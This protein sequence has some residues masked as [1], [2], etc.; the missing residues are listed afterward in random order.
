MVQRINYFFRIPKLMCVVSIQLRTKSQPISRVL[1]RTAIY[2]GCLSPNTSSDLPKLQHEPR[3]RVFIWSCSKWGLPC[4]LCYHKCGV[5]LPRLFTLTS[6]SHSLSTYGK[7]G[8]VRSIFCGTIHG[9]AS[10]RRYLAFCSMEPGLS[11]IIKNMTA[12]VQPTLNS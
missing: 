3:Y 8:E 4:H 10:P 6:L 11:S 9:L 7:W 5:L 2:L 1:S 12:T